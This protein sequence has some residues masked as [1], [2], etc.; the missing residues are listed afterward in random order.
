MNET[1]RLTRAELIDRHK[2]ARASDAQVQAIWDRRNQQGQPACYTSPGQPI[3]EARTS[4]PIVSQN[5]PSIDH[6]I[7]TTQE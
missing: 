1:I 7:T 6:V 2:R 4:K 3:P 5:K